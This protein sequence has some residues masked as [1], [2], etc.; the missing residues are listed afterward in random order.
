MSVAAGRAE[1][2]VSD[3]CERAVGQVVM[4]MSAAVREG[5]GPSRRGEQKVEEK[6]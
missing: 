5:Q 6:Q 1:V 4:Q 3:L 2:A